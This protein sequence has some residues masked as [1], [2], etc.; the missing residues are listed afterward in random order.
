MMLGIG[1]YGLGLLAGLLS[2]LSP[3]VLPIVPI[4]LGSAAAAHRQA[5]L[6]LAAG[7]A[8]SYAVVGSALAWAGVSLGLDTA[9]FRGVGAAL[10]GLLGVVLIS[11]AL[12]QRFALLTSGIGNAGNN[13]LARIPLDGLAG[14]FAVGLV[15]GVVWS[16]CV[17][18]TLGAAVVLA[19]Q[20]TNLVQAGFMMAVFGIGAAL[21]LVALAYVSRSAMGRMRS[22][23]MQAARTGKILLGTVMV[24]LAVLILTGAD[25]PMEAWLVEHSPAWLTHLTTQF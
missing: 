9:V 25:R 22:G 18:P 19:S 1:S 7:L 16:P 23:L 2:T 21:P 8:L 6:A 24:A 14:Q 10:L 20:G 12:Q 4:L 11:G 3:C 13:L 17:G 5:P 15:L